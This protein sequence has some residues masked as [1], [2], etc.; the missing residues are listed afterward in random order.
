M[1]AADRLDAAARSLG[2]LRLC[3]TRPA[4]VT[5]LRASRRSGGGRCLRAENRPHRAR[6]ERACQPGPHRRR[7][8]RRSRPATPH[9]GGDYR[10]GRRPTWARANPNEDIRRRQ[11]ETADRLVVTKVDAAEPERLRR[12][13][14]TLRILN[15]GAAISV[16]IVG[17]QPICRTPRASIPRPCR[18]Q[19]VAG[20]RCQSEPLRWTSATPPTGLRS[21]Y[22]LAR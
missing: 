18:P 6:N 5:L 16:T 12:L 22:G 1:T 15:P 2:R 10:D 11:I 19:A 20:R 8:S 7:H 14:A 3:E 13:V 21:R 17:S 9:R 4:L